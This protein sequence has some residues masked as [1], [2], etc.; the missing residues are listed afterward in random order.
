MSHIVPLDAFA[1]LTN[2]FKK[3]LEKVNGD[4]NKASSISDCDDLVLFDFCLTAV[5]VRYLTNRF[6]G[7]YCSG[8]GILLSDQLFFSMSIWRYIYM[9]TTA[10]KTT[11][12]NGKEMF[13]LTGKCFL[14]DDNSCA[15]DDGLKFEKPRVPR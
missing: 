5:V 2:L 8:T 3:R 10:S 9:V 11:K 7:E 13:A 1:T 4:E 15:V 6:I 12:I 14:P